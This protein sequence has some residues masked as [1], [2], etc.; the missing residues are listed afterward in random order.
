MSPGGSPRLARITIFPLKSFDGVE[1]EE[2]RVRGDAGLEHD[3]EYRLAD[4]N[5]ALNGKRL[6]EKLIR[7]RS[8][9]DL[10]FGELTLSADGDRLAVR[11]PRGAAELE[12]W[13]GARLGVPV[14]LERDERKGFPD[15]EEA[16]G[17]TIVSRATLAEVGSWFGI[18][19][20]EARRRFRANLEIDGVPAFWEDC[21]YGPVGET[22]P[23]QI[24][25]VTFEGVNPCA[26]CAV[27]SRDSRS[28]EI[29]EP[30]FAKIFA[31]RRRAALPEWAEASRF[32]HS[33]R[34][35]VNTRLPL[36][37]NGKTLHH[38]DEVRLT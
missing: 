35:A 31:D 26:R 7:I 34:L 12:A 24:G 25:E 27:P 38:G 3:R 5:G 18:G 11:L 4:P 9:F 16:S 13:L 17:P 23:F 1:V 30:R 6:A 21:L 33:Y 20:A 32:D 14:S 2:T 37:E 10:A 19:E 8:W 29:F 28:G 15:D 22:R 36:S